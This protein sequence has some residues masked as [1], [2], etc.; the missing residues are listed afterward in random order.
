M[1]QKRSTLATN[2]LNARHALKLTQGAVAERVGV[3]IEAVSGWEKD[4]YVPATDNLQALAQVLDTTVDKLLSEQSSFREK[5]RIF[6]ESHMSTFLKARFTVGE[7]KMS[8]EAL[9]FAKKHHEG[10]FRDKKKTVP[11]IN[12]P[13]TMAC[14]A[15][16]LGI[17]DDQLVA[18]ILLHDIVEMSDGRLS[19]VDL[20]VNVETKELVRILTDSDVPKKQYYEKIAANP[21]A[22]LIACMDRVNNLSTMPI[23]FTPAK[24]AAYVKRT[25][26]FIV[27]L[28]KV[29]KEQAEYN[30]AA[31]ALTYQ[32]QGLLNAYRHFL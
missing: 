4:K 23:L 12:H 6:D 17:A 32:I 5:N 11:Y 30:N 10:H 14:Q 7:W 29:V 31:W 24:M 18:A 16:A 19:Y 27:P 20:P 8:A 1:E 21:K 13:L 22:A 25:E 2:I 28:L 26:E 3:S 15:F 9:T